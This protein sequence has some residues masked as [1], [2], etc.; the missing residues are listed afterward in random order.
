MEKNAALSLNLTATTFGYRKRLKINFWNVRTLLDSG[1]EN[2]QD[3]SVPSCTRIPTI[4]SGHSWPKRIEIV[5]PEEYFFSF[6]SIVLLYFG[7]Q[8][9]GSLLRT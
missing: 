9:D 8:S 7:K 2:P 4:L 6:C 1:I 5:G 3:G